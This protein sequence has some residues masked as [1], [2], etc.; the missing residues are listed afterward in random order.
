[1]FKKKYVWIKLA[2]RR[3]NKYTF[4]AIMI[5][6]PIADLEKILFKNNYFVRKFCLPKHHYLA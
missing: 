1:M 2:F 3:C 4:L 5:E 6:R